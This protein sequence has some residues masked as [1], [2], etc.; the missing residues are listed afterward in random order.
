MRPHHNIHQLHS[1]AAKGKP[2]KAKRKAAPPGQIYRLGP[3]APRREDAI[4]RFGIAIGLAERGELTTATLAAALDL[5]KHFA[6]REIVEWRLRGWLETVDGTQ[7]QARTDATL[8]AVYAFIREHGGI[9][10]SQ[11]EPILEAHGVAS[12]PKKWLGKSYLRGLLS[13]LKPGVYGLPDEQNGA[14]E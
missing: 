8:E 1:V 5:P 6:S 14:A 13:R 10:A 11:A 2:A 4:P 12:V 9:S 3:R 7:R